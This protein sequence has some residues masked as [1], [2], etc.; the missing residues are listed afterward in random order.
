[1]EKSEAKPSRASGLPPVLELADL[2]SQLLHTIFGLF[3]VLGL[4]AL[5]MGIVQSLRQGRLSFAFPY[6]AATALAFVVLALARRLPFKLTVFSFLT[7]LYA[8]AVVALSRL[9]LS[10]GG[11]MLLLSFTLLAAIL[12]SPRMGAVALLLGLA[13]I[14]AV[15]W[16]MVT[17]HIQAPPGEDSVSTSPVAWID[18][19]LVFA[20]V[21]I[22]THRASQILRGHLEAS[23]VRLEHDRGELERTSEARAQAEEELR[24][25]EQRYRMVI[26]NARDAVFIAQDNVLKFAN[27]STV[28]ATGRSREELAAVPFP[29]YVHPDDRHLVLANYQKRLRGEALPHTY[30]FRILRKDGEIVWIELSAVPIVWEGRSASLNFARNVT[31]QRRTQER[32]NRTQKLQAVGTLAGGIAHDFNN[33]LQIVQGNAELLDL[34][35]P[36]PDRSKESIADILEAAR[37]GSSLANRLLGLTRKSEGE[38]RSIDPNTELKRVCELLGRTFPKTIAIEIQ[39]EP[40]LPAVR[41]VPGELGHA[42]MNLAINA[43]DAMPGGGRLTVQTLRRTLVESDCDAMPGLLPGRHVVIRVS[44]T[45]TGMSE[46]TIAHLFEPFY[47]TKGAGAGT[48]LGLAMVYGIVHAHNGF[49][50][51]QST[52]GRGTVFEITLPCSPTDTLEDTVEP[53]QRLPEGTETVLVV[54]DEAQVRAFDRRALE[55]FGYS[56]ICADGCEAAAELLSNPAHRVDLVVLDVIMPST[57][58]WSC[59]RQIGRLRPGL[60][61]LL[62]SA[63]VQDEAEARFAEDLGIRALLKPYTLFELLT[64]VRATLDEPARGSPGS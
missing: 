18:V 47:T 2:R 28:E 46:E 37:R 8:A 1:M 57:D 36:D 4:P 49:V 64:A 52:V 38:L 5:A 60:K 17:G 41:A 25:S 55:T 19:T 59:L 53:A 54:D 35:A 32:L 7:L 21:A 63:Y 27:P 51:C 22:T 45:G 11:T 9:G 44:D 39:L 3:L 14:G 10:G 61:V 23:L 16:A 33:L 6:V 13:A 40:G 24:R 48:G 34:A 20:L 50:G 43:R 30:T 62:A 12:V 56:V 29:D 15:C 58:G 42:V 31:D 26:E